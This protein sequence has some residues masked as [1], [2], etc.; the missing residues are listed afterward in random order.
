M[1]YGLIDRKS[2]QYY[3]YMSKVFQAIDN[4][5]T[6]YNWLVTGCEC[7]PKDTEIEKLFDQEYCWL[8]GDDLTAIIQ[9]EDFQWIWGCLCGFPKE[10]SLED[11][12]KYPLPS[13][14]DYKGYYQNPVMLQHPLSHI[15]IIPGDSSWMLL[16]SKDKTITDRYLRSYPICEELSLFNKR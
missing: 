6:Q 13:A 15:E 9:K 14:E 8:S 4:V 12:L 16:I 3:T 5:Q 7:Y 1:I 2:H 11:V 10:T